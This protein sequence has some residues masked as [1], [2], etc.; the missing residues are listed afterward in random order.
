[1]NV[2]Q[3]LNQIQ[4]STLSEKKT[5]NLIKYLYDD[6]LCEYGGG[7]D[8]FVESYS[9]EVGRFE[10][11]RDVEIIESLYSR[12]FYSPNSRI[13][14]HELERLE[15]LLDICKNKLYSEV[16]KIIEGFMDTPDSEMIQ[17]DIFEKEKHIQKPNKMNEQIR[18]KDIVIDWT[19][20]GIS[21]ED[22]N[23]Q[24]QTKRL[25]D[26]V[27]IH[28]GKIFIYNSIHCNK[29]ELIEWTLINQNNLTE[30]DVWKD[31]GGDNLSYT[32][33]IFHEW[34]GL[35]VQSFSIEFICSDKLEK[36]DMV[37]LLNNPEDTSKMDYSTSYGKSTHEDFERI[38][39]NGLSLQ[40]KDDLEFL[41]EN[42]EEREV[43]GFENSSKLV[44]QLNELLNL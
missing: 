35:S 6:I 20:T 37:S 42:F 32:E 36:I 16:W 28:D 15:G 27:F 44:Q 43:H 41:Y 5:N 4:E 13:Q 30:L 26:R 23:L 8:S 18:F 33:T 3:V 9:S 38:I 25:E 22:F 31:C 39:I 2:K 10:E 24:G 34:F 40:F 21:H 19:T 1:M 11:Q 12:R 29:N 17:D 14:K 7:Y